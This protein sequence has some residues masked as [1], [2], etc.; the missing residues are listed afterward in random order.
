MGDGSDDRNETPGGLGVGL[1]DALE[2]LRA[3]L[4]RAREMAAGAD[5]QLPID[6][7][8]VEI[9]AVVTSDRRGRVGFRVP[10]VNAEVGG[11]AGMGSERIQ[12]LT[13]ELGTPVDAE[14]RPVKVS[15]RSTQAKN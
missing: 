9:K 4:A 5:L 14:G 3:D 12:T 6:G 10:F 7:V 15:A 8:T 13:L 11:E 1:A 2:A